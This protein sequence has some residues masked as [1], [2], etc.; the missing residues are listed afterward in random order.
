MSA[1]NWYY[2]PA[3]GEVMQ[4]TMRSWSN[5]MGPYSSEEEARN[6]LNIAAARNEAA[7]AE[8]EA[9]R[10]EDEDWGTWQN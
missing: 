8:E 6:A 7:A 5:R 10:E 4:G 9:E 1:N 2:N 3:T